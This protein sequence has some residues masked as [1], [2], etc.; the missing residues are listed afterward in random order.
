MKKT[1]E[2]CYTITFKGLLSLYLDTQLL[3]KVMEAV[4]LQMYR[5]E[6]NAIV[7]DDLQS[8]GSFESVVRGNK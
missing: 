4:E 7:F 5:G 8:G 1:K 3:D 6:T 2:A